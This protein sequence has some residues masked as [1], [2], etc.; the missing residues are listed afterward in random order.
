MPP[1]WRKRCRRELV[2][3]FGCGVNGDKGDCESSSK[4]RLKRAAESGLLKPRIGPVSA[5]DAT[6]VLF[7]P[8]VQIAIGPVF[9]ALAQLQC[10]S[11]ADNCRAHLW[12]PA[13]D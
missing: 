7:N 13:R 6:M 10:G 11:R 12:L 8:I 4:P 5:F 1:R 3:I 9:H 2:G